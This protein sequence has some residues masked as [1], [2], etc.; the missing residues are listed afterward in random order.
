MKEKRSQIS[1]TGANEFV[2]RNIRKFRS[3]NN[4]SVIS[5]TRSKCLPLK[6]ETNVRYSDLDQE[7]L[8]P[9]LNN[10]DT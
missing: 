10:C 4:T 5:I 7:N 2:G 3:H 9:K 6:Y 1:I 8:I